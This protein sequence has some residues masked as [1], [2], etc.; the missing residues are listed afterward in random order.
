[1]KNN[2][3]FKKIFVTAAAASIAAGFV[4]C[5]PFDPNDNIAIAM[6]GPAPVVE[7]DSEKDTNDTAVHA[8]TEK[9]EPSGEQPADSE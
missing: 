1:M 5:D 6:Y 8:D 3:R 4:A 9:D 7:R 2:K